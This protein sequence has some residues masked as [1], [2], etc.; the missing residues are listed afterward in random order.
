[1]QTP[2]R[3]TKRQIASTAYHEAAHAVVAAALG[4]AVDWIKV[5]DPKLESGLTGECS[6]D[7]RCDDEDEVL[8][9]LAGIVAD[10]MY[11]NL[12]SP[13][14]YTLYNLMFRFS[15]GDMNDFRDSFKEF[16]T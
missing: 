11:A 9:S 7:T 3:R 2:R 6:R 10:S 13:Y 4:Y 12:K 8:I 16:M 5:Y 14:S 1:M 15:R